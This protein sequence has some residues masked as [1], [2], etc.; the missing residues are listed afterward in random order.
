LFSLLISG[1]ILP[2]TSFYSFYNQKYPSDI[3][4]NLKGTVLFAQSTIIPSLHQ[5]ENDIQPHLVANRTTLILFKPQDK[6]D[7]KKYITV[8]VYNA[9]HQLIFKKKMRPY[10]QPIQIDGIPPYQLS[11]SY[12]PPY[13]IKMSDKDTI[14][15]LR[16]DLTGKK[17][18]EL[19]EQ[20][21]HLH[22]KTTNGAFSGAIHIP[23]IKSYGRKYITIES[24]SDMDSRIHFSGKIRTLTTGKSI[25]LKLHRNTWFS[26]YDK[27]MASIT[28]GDF[29][30]LV[31]PKE[32]IQPGLF[33][34][35]SESNKHGLLREESIPIEP[36]IDLILHTIDLGFLTSYRDQFTF[37][38][39]D[40]AQM[41]FY[42]SIPVSRMIISRYAPVSLFDIVLPHGQHYN[43]TKPHTGQGSVYTGDMRYYIGKLLISHGINLAQ[44][45]LNASSSISE[46]AHHYLAAQITLHNA[47]GLYQNGLQIH[48]LSGGNGVVTL[49]DSIGNEFSHELGHA[50]GLSHFA[51]DFQG[52]IHRKSSE[53]NSTWGWDS[54]KNIFIPNF[55]PETTHRLTSYYNPEKRDP[56]NGKHVSH[57]LNHDFSKDAMA[58]GKPYYT[59]YYTLYTPYSL[60]HIQKFLL[61]TARFD[62]HSSTGFS[63]WNFLHKM[64]EPYENTISGSRPEGYEI[65]VITLVGYY[66]PQAKIKGKAY[67]ALYGSYGFTYPEK[68]KKPTACQLI[69]HNAT[70]SK[71]FYLAD[72][73]FDTG[74][75]NKYHVNIAQSFQPQS[76]DLICSQKK[77]LH[78]IIE[79]PVKLLHTSVLHH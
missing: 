24:N 61:S 76:L 56:D 41:D 29:W 42:Q 17:I 54:I 11:F 4:G 59:N 32:H 7:D 39:S 49:K 12:P 19:L 10:T 52:S 58:G 67:P 1:W 45:G 3:V 9:E 25:I 46:S 40:K 55:N 28:Y 69:V 65:P 64:Y 16:Q 50:F 37:Q 18:K 26:H 8:H 14:N 78:R 44:Y 79:P 72:T 22:I 60:H 2:P 66:D 48:G 21:H 5:I 75:M 20:H 23:K 38:K 73:R 68:A 36:Q 30:S 53:P 33:I 35:F 57:Y 6:I 71:T 27:K 51:G 43:L 34:R 47:Q 77:L 74:Y 63:K 13:D 70:Q 15:A 62:E 31:I